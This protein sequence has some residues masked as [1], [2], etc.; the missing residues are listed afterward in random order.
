MPGY[1]NIP[2]K[3]KVP[4]IPVD[5][6]K[7]YAEQRAVLLDI[8]EEEGEIGKAL[9]QIKSGFANGTFDRRLAELLQLQTSIIY[10]RKTKLCIDT[11]HKIDKPLIESEVEKSV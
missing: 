5:Y 10:N 4:K 7:L 1:A 2:P 8:I 3:R 6:M 11:K 9:L